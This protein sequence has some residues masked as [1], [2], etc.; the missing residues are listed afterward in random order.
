MIDD[1][2]GFLNVGICPNF[3]TKGKSDGQSLP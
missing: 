1:L 2:A 3:N